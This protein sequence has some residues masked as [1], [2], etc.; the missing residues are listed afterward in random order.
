MTPKAAKG[1]HKGAI[2][3]Y[4]KPPITEVVCGLRFEPLADFKIPHIGL[5]WDKFRKDYPSV[6]HAI[7]IGTE[8]SIIVDPL[9]GAPLPRV[10]F[11]NTQGNQLVQFQVDRYYFNWRQRGDEYPRYPRIIEAYESVKATLD[12]FLREM[13]L[14]PL[15]PVEYEL[16]YINHIPKGQGWESADDLP[17]I[18]TDFNWKE[19][20]NRFL[21]KPANV[22]WQTRFSL[23]DDKG[24]LIA[25][26]NQGKRKEDELPVLVLELAARGMS[27]DMR[28]WFDLAREWIVRGFDDLTTAKIQTTNWGRVRDTTS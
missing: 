21:P 1:A 18:F 10:W 2:P 20:Q 11:I 14:E 22:S 7:P 25:K 23:P 16:T 4:K 8:T 24:W 5:L 27:P 12:A 19:R 17:Q 3:S 15:K 9:T 26:L 6:E 13:K 28:Q